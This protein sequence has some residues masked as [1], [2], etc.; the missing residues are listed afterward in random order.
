MKPSRVDRI[1]EQWSSAA[2]AA[3]RPADAPR[4][5]A[6]RS[7]FPVATLS[8]AAL[9]IVAVAV[10]GILL[11]RPGPNPIA[12]SEPSTS[13]SA[14]ASVDARPSAS[15]PVVGPGRPS[16][17][18]AC[19]PADVAVRITAWDGAAGSRIAH[20]TL[21]NQGASE[22]SLDA[23]ARPQL[24]D[25]RGDVLI[26]GREPTDRATLPLAPGATVQTLVEVSNLCGA[27]PAPPISVAFVLA[28]GRRVLADPA[29][30]TDATVPPCNGTAA[31]AVID[32]HPWAP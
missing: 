28:D 29:S 24:V 15:V 21:V 13:S 9:V 16:A 25:G 10:A 19:D 6:V 20:V 4:P 22:C 3:R 8:G 1:L 30:P 26:D 5:I 32:M 11:G 23:M 7:G 14:D 27:T 18:V 12:G 31:P 17:V 2:G